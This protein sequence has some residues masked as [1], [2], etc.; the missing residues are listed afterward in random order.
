[1]NRAGEQGALPARNS[2]FYKR[3]GYFY[4]STR[5]GFDIGPFDTLQEAQAGASAFIDFVLHAEPH[6]LQCLIRYSSAA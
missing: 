4:Y 3:D 2:R 1:M 5:E 6:E